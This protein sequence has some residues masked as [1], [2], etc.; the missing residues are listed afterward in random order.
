MVNNTIEHGQ[1]A[2]EYFPIIFVLI[3]VI[4]EVGRQRK[5]RKSRGLGARRE[6][7]LIFEKF[8]LFPG[9]IM[10]RFSVK[11]IKEA[12]KIISQIQIVQSENIVD[13][14]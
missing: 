1:K 4:V 3:R 12:K 2:R 13:G 11:N 5:K 8:L 6:K 14:T 7:Y 9:S 10:E